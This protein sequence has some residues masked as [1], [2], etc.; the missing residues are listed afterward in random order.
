MAL[1]KW[2]SNASF[3]LSPCQYFGKAVRR[4][5][6]CYVV[7]WIQA[8]LCFSR[9][10]PTPPPP[11][12][13]PHLR[14]HGLVW[15]GLT[16]VSD[17]LEGPWGWGST[18]GGYMPTVGG[19]LPHQHGQML[20]HYTPTAPNCWQLDAA[21]Y[22]VMVSRVCYWPVAVV[23]WRHFLVKHIGAVLFF[24]IKDGPVPTAVENMRSHV[25]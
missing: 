4:D 15:Y 24:N 25:M 2:L 17:L 8:V 21:C 12:S 3:E 5:N 16:V 7:G 19:Y 13:P 11:P 10:C 9:S 18:V 6:S 14:K 22:Q 1:D 20:A 23:Y